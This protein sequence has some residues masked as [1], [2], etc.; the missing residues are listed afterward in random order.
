[1]IIWPNIKRLNG[2]EKLNEEDSGE[3]SEKS[4]QP[5]QAKKQNPPFRLKR[6]P[7]AK[8]L[9][10]EE[11]IKV[12]RPEFGKWSGTAEGRMIL[13]RSQASHFLF[14]NPQSEIRN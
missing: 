10:D 13:K 6:I 9:M 12:R 14:R 4:W 5:K 3:K 2:S 11:R 1:V 7:D 8:S